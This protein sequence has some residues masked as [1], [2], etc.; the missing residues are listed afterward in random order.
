MPLHRLRLQSYHRFWPQ[1]FLTRLCLITL[2]STLDPRLLRTALH[3]RCQLLL[4][5]GEVERCHRGVVACH[6]TRPCQKF[7]RNYATRNLAPP[8]SATLGS[9]F[10]LLGCVG[11]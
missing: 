1:H 8:H 10:H 5:G 11:R 7:A 3:Q 6:R 4:A 9:A 2:R